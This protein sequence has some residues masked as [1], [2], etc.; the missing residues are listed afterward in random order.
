MIFFA[1]TAN[2]SEIDYC[3][4]VG[5]NDGITTNPKI[6]ES[7]GD[8][9][10]GF[11]GACRAI[12]QK[13]PNVPV[14]LETDLRGIDV[15]TLEST[16]PRKVRDVL[17]QQ[18]ETLSSL[19]DNVIVKIP[20]CY[21]GLLAAEELAKRGIRTNVTACMTP[22]QALTA[23]RFGIGYVS[24]FANRMLD[25][26]ILDLSGYS[27]EEITTN[28]YWKDLV[29]EAKEKYFEEAWHRT[30]GQISYVAS[31]LDSN[32]NSDL[33]IGSIRSPKDIYRIAQ[34]HP[35]VIT[36]PTK[37]VHGLENIFELKQTKR[38]FKSNGIILG[39]SIS[40]PMTDYTLEEFEKAADS[41]RKV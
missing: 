18:A 21:G 30:L 39:E 34:T 19:G 14:S 26:H 40:H 1:D 24:L 9:S 11:D 36:I 28:S 13:Y 29:A 3:F 15:R 22:Y 2:L 23:S 17:L 41:Y 7:T 5:V 25:S 38:S 12:L 31:E 10:L 33:I 6:I 16:D 8:L 4:S 27:L 20:I 35:Q 37:I 32:P